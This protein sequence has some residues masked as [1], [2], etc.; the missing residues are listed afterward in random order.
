M[1]N[2][3]L[4]ESESENN[5]PL[6]EVRGEAVGTD[7]QIQGRMILGGEEGTI[8]SLAKFGTFFTHLNIFDTLGT[9]IVGAFRG[10]VLA[11]FNDIIFTISGINISDLE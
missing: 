2:E 9:L 7:I 8:G 5:V 11:I 6:K 3:I 10:N 4:I 1:L